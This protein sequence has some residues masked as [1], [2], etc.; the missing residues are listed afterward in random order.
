MYRFNIIITELCNATC[1]HCYMGNSK[2]SKTMTKEEID[3]IINKLPKDTESVVLTGG[4]IFLK[5]TLLFYTIKKI[6]KHNKNIIIKLES[7]GIYFYKDLENA[8]QKLI[9]LKELGVES[10]RFS[11]D[12]FHS[13]GGIDLEKVRNLKELED[14]NTPKIKYLVQDKALGIGKAK[15]LKN[16]QLDIRNCM[17]NKDTINNPYFFINIHG[18]VFI[19][20]WKCIPPIGNIINE[21]MNLIL[22][23]LNEEFNILILQGKIVKAIKLLDNKNHIKYAKKHGECLLC[24]KYFNKN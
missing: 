4:E 10:I 17:N 11:D 7:N 12:P 18:D 20:T 23:R 21:D 3:I 5:K 16:D 2:K 13:T 19:C 15:S 22:S 8:K 1:S 6:K 14:I 9:E 24:D